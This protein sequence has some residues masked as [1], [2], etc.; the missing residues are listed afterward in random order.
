HVAAVLGTL[1][2]LGLDRIISPRRSRERDL[3]VARLLDPTSKLATARGFDPQ[4]C[5]HTLAEELGIEAASADELY[6]AMDWLLSQQERMETELAQRHLAGGQLVLYDV[7][8]AYF[9][10]RHCPLA[11][12]QRQPPERRNQ[13]ASP[14]EHRQANEENCSKAT[15]SH[16][17]DQAF[18][19][20]EPP[21]PGRTLVR[22]KHY[23][24][25]SLRDLG[26]G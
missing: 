12:L 7:T 15:P 14:G 22:T 4:T 19:F 25:S 23:E 20:K 17:R 11:H 26:P 16:R 10:G 2:R 13:T 18:R 21:K 6:A 3:V 9:E 1:Q 24:T 5:H 8:S